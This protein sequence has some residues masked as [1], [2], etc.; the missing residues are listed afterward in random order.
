MSQVSDNL[1]LGPV[2]LPGQ[3]DANSPSSPQLG[4]GPLGRVY[5]W[6]I[7]PLTLNATGLATAQAGTGG[8]VALTAGT[9]VTSRVDGNGLTRL[10]LDVPRAVS[11]TAA[12]ANTQTAIVTG[13]DQY[14]QRMTETFAAPSTNTVTGKKAFKEILSILFAATP[15]SNVS[16]G[17]SDVF[18][19][20]YSISDFVYI[21][22]I[23]WAQ[24]LA[25]Q[26]A[27]VVVADATTPALSTT[28]DVRGTVTPSSASNGTR[29]MVALLAL[30]GAQVGPQGTR[31]SLAGVNQA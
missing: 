22:S 30:T 26:A 13:Y 11:L 8:V 14:G 18:G 24:T 4:A 17:T 10:V 12:G 5:V 31:L 25:D 23:K 3:V 16:A 9:G 21:Q 1:F 29:R 20:P 27:T 2:Y 28:G 19:L 6:D 15:G 7:L